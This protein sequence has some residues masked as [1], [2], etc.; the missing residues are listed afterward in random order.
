MVPKYKICHHKT[1]RN[2]Y[3]EMILKVA[4]NN[5]KMRTIVNNSIS[6]EIGT[7]KTRHVNCFI[8]KYNCNACDK[9]YVNF[10]SLLLCLLC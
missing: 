6:A 10:V 1:T 4:L 2:I 7:L 9:L 3:L 8:V 5:L